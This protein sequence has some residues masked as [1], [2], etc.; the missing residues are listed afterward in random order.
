MFLT[1]HGTKKS[2][3]RSRETLYPLM[4][5]TARKIKRKYVGFEKGRERETPR[6]ALVYIYEMKCECHGFL[7]FLMMLVPM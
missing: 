3:H 6:A 5:V 7:S 4:R 1:N 2:L